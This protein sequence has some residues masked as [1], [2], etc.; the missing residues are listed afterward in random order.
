MS[1]ILMTK[2]I[3]KDNINIEIKDFWQEIRKHSEKQ[4]WVTFSWISKTEKC[5]N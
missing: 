3:S 4:K 5:N 2:C 1:K